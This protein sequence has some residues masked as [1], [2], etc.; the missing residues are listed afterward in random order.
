MP[1]YLI[2][3][4]NNLIYSLIVYSCHF[5]FEFQ[6][7]FISAELKFKM[8]FTKMSSQYSTHRLKFILRGGGVPCLENCPRYL[9]TA[10][11]TEM[12]A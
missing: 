10:Y 6:Q 4:Y 1:A 2:S 8:A 9:A 3:V 7:L 12:L 11:N 5:E